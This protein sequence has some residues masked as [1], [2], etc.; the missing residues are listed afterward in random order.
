MENEQFHRLK[1]QNLFHF[2][3]PN[4]TIIEENRRVGQKRTKN[5]KLACLKV[6]TQ[7]FPNFTKTIEQLLLCFSIPRL[8]RNMCIC[9]EKEYL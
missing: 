2:S 4:C 7:S 9:T 1:M 6:E 8:F 5:T 3:V